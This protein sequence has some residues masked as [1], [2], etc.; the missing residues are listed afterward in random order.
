M[1]PQLCRG[2]KE[3]YSKDKLNHIITEVLIKENITDFQVL[4]KQENM[5][6]N[7]ACA[8]CKNFHKPRETFSQ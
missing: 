2:E 7:H 8:P 3:N 1:I 6:Q 4:T 5:L